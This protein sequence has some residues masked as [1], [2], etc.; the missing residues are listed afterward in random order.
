M[1][2]SS[3]RPTDF[4]PIK[5]KRSEA[6]PILERR[7]QRVTL[8]EHTFD[9]R[10]EAV[11]ALANS[12]IE[13][14]C[15]GL[16]LSQSATTPIS[17]ELRREHERKEAWDSSALGFLA[18]AVSLGAAGLAL[19]Q[20]RATLLQT[21]LM[22]GAG[23]AVLGMSAHSLHSGFKQ[24]NE[25]IG[26]DD[27]TLVEHRIEERVLPKECCEGEYE[28]VPQ[29]GREI[30]YFQVDADPSDQDS[31]IFQPI[32]EGHHQALSGKVTPPALYDEGAVI[33]PDGSRRKL[34]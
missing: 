28:I 3:T 32:F 18:G 5:K 10:A 22:V 24:A 14:P 19:Y 1:N 23:T 27:Y 7:A 21:G 15:R 4:T 33:Y 12:T 20:G 9:T 30:N 34:G 26:P 31:L 16:V 13:V 8:G 6:E 25:G 11:E 17:P 29:G 2:I